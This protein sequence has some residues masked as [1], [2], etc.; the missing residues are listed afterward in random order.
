M[1]K[2]GPLSATVL[3][4]P[5]A[6]L[7][8]IAVGA[9]VACGGSGS[10]DSASGGTSSGDPGSSGGN[11]GNDGG[12][13]LEDG[14]VAATLACQSENGTAAVQMPTFVR[15]VKTG[16]TGWFASPAVVDLDKNGTMEIVA[17]LYSTIVFDAQGKQLGAK[18][19]ATM[20]RVYAPHVVADLD[21]DGTMEIVVGGNNGTVAAYEWKNGALAVKQGW[22][23]STA[24][25]GQTP[26]ARGMAAA[27]LDNDGKLEVV[28]TTTNTSPT[29]AQVFVFSADGKLFAPGGKTDAWPRYN[30]AAG[31]DQDFNGYGNHGYG[32]Y[33]ENVGIGNIDDDKQL[34]ILVTY[35]DHQINAFKPDGT[36]ILASSWYTNPQS[37]FLGQRMGWGQFIR[38]ADFKVDEDHYHLHAGAFP[39]VKQTM[40]L[41]WTASPPNVVDI[42][43]DG[44]NEVVGIPNAE[45]KEPYETQAYAFMVLEGA[46][47]DGARSARRKA[48]FETL[49][50]TDKPAVRGDTDYYPPSGIPTPTTV[51][52]V[53]DARPEIVAPINDGYIYAIGP[54]GSRL[55]RY[56]FAQGRAKTFASEVVVADLNKDGTP[57]LIF[58]TYSLDANGGHVIVLANTGKLLFDVTL[59]GQGTDG[60]GIGRRSDYRR[61]RRRWSARDRRADVRPRHRSADRAGLRQGVHAVADRTRQPAPQRHGPEHRE[62]ARSRFHSRCRSR[63]RQ[64]K[65]PPW[66]VGSASALSPG[67]GASPCASAVS[68]ASRIAFMMSAPAA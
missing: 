5:I 35:D 15:N 33:G 48:G 18:G 11:G 49:P 8:T 10:S 39:D 38:W 2:R 37:M 21:G 60:N 46:H 32:C 64:K 1:E 52:I 36:S 59:P 17:A 55:W 3:A 47:G 43:G 26:E 44:K 23:T 29:G 68:C 66:S 51:N 7:V 6:G 12:I 42:D 41:Q 9:F 57:E 14:A 31:G 4:L 22:P 27:D 20:G 24:S 63:F 53:G 19:T 34:E 65:L 50:T 13:V 30:T 16:E 54:D 58:G 61:P 40:W 56:D 67:V 28:V 45:L 62:V 25:G